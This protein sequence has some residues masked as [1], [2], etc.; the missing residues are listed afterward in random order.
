MAPRGT[1]RQTAEDGTV[2]EIL[3]YCDGFAVR[4][5]LIGGREV[6]GKAEKKRVVWNLHAVTTCVSMYM[7]VICSLVNTT[8]IFQKYSENTTET[9][10]MCP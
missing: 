1:S 8:L 2:G 5:V 3:S 4:Y 10:F 9:Y 7:Y 6:L